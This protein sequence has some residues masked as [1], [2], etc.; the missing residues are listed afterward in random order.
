MAIAH[1]DTVERL[2]IASNLLG[3][4]ILITKMI[5]GVFHVFF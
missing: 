1:I 3:V 4:K 2:D 5:L